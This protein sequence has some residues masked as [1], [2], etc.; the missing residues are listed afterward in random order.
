LLIPRFF[1]P[2]FD[3]NWFIRQ[4]RFN[5]PLACSLGSPWLNIKVCKTQADQCGSFFHPNHPNSWFRYILTIYTIYIY[6]N[7]S[8]LA[9]VGNML[10]FFPLVNSSICI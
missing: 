8:K 5:R 9:N 10:L 4:P 7:S 6:K 2:T 1:I 3:D